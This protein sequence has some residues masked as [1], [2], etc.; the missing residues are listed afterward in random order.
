MTR[1]D[2]IT[3][4]RQLRHE[5]LSQRAIARRLDISKDTVRRDFDRLDAESAPDDAPEDPDAPQA[6]EA[7]AA[8]DAPQDAPPADPGSSV[9]HAR[10]IEDAP[11]ALPRR[12]PAHDRL[13]VDVD[14]AQ[15]PKLRVALAEL[16]TTGVDVER[17]IVQGLVTL[18]AGYRQGVATGD[19]PYGR[20][21]HVLMLRVGPP[22]PGHVTPR[23]AFP[24][25][26]VE[27]A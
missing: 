19:I 12:I 8:E 21:F 14:L 15:W 3:L 18:A 7:P 2:R 1:T 10:P 5:G 26:P 27:G 9:A 13:A 4:V 22:E 25:A 6:S 20:P 16:A 24:P 11:P 17:L 23:R